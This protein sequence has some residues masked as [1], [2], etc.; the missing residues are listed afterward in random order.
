MSGS[1]PDFNYDDV[2]VLAHQRQAWSE[3]DASLEEQRPR[4]CAGAR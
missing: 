4:D 2:R 3:C 1:S